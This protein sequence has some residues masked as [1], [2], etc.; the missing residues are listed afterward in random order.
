MVEPITLG[1]LS[2]VALTEGIKFLYAQ[3]GE[4]LKG[5]RARGGGDV[6]VSSIEAVDAEIVEGDLQ[7]ATPDWDAVE[8]LGGDLRVLR[9]QL[10]DYIDGIEPVGPD[11]LA[12]LETGEALRKMLEVIMRQ[13][14]TFTGETRRASAP[15]IVGQADLD[16]VAGYAAAVRARLVER[17][18]IHGRLQARR[19]EQGAKAIAVDIDQV[20]GSGISE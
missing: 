12:L 9:S 15:V 19:V 1:A 5:W 8:R 3:A 11:D 14:I 2:G 7:L 17:G 6:S 20:G 18:E 10:A 4:V 13:R 16:E